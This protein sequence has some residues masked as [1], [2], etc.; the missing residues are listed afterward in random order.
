MDSIN[1]TI[2][3]FHYRFYSYKDIISFWSLWTWIM[4]SSF[5]GAA[6]CFIWFMNFISFDFIVV[7]KGYKL[8]LS[9]CLI[10]IGVLSVIRFHCLRDDAAIRLCQEEFD[11]D[12]KSYAQLK[13]MWFKK[14]LPYKRS[15]YIALAENIDSALTLKTKYK[16]P[17][18]YSKKD[19]LDHIL[20][21]DSKNRMLA[22]FM[23]VSTFVV[24]LSIAYGS[25]IETVFEFYKSATE[26]QLFG[27]FIV[28]PIIFFIGIVELKI[29]TVFIV[30]LAELFLDNFNGINGFSHLRTETFI[31]QLIRHYSFEKPRMKVKQNSVNII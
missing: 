28:F 25:S 31:N 10:F 8:I 4:I 7:F 17:I 13:I 18:D 2:N 14:H 26:Q 5:L 29:I 3:R 23:G 19:I 27:F 24:A 11:V 20:S 16:S 9:M 15:E 1:N 6:V 30:R 22:M 12:I 21:N